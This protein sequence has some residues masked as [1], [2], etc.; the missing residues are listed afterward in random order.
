MGVV[1]R[2]G[3]TVAVV[4][5]SD[6]PLTRSGW[7]AMLEATRKVTVVAETDV[8]EEAESLAAR[9]PVSVVVLDAE[10]G[11]G[12]GLETVRRIRRGS[13]QTSVV[14][15]TSA[16]KPGSARR[17]LEAGACAYLTKTDSPKDLEAAV[18]AAA[19]GEEYRQPSLAS[20]IEQDPEPGSAGEISDREQD[21]LRLLALG[22]TNKEIAR[23]L[24]LSVRTVETHRAS[25]LRKLGASNRAELVAH[26]LRSGLVGGAS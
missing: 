3:K 21:V 11:G 14:V 12:A 19:K 17:A 8:P 10:M 24:Y 26:A 7:K 25:L 5:A 13:P 9:D 20:L 18:S 1:T 6:E 16:D 15:V 2:N 4:L 22:Y 23:R